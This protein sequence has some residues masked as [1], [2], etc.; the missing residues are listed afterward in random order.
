ILSAHGAGYELLRLDRSIAGGPVLR[1]PADQLQAKSE[2]S[3]FQRALQ[4]T[5]T[6][7]LLTTPI[8]WNREH[9][10]VAEPLTLMVRH[11]V[12]R[13]DAAGRPTG[14]FVLNV[15]ILDQLTRLLAE[16]LTAEEA[17]G[18]VVN[19]EEQWIVPP[20]DSAKRPLVNARPLSSIGVAD[21]LGTDWRARMSSRST[22]YVN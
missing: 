2:E 17:F 5:S 22:T 3:Y 7:P 13:F 4:V 18:F 8:T 10:R 11:T 15:G 1:V 20:V 16:S 14:V 6:A 21:L 19:E 9:G 12:T